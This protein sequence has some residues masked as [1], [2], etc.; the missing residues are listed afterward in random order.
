MWQQHSDSSGQLGLYFLHIFH[1][2]LMVSHIF[3]GPQRLEAQWFCVPGSCGIGHSTTEWYQAANK[4][5][6]N[7]FFSPS[8]WNQELDSVS[9]HT[10]YY[11]WKPACFPRKESVAYSGSGKDWKK[12]NWFSSFRWK[13]AMLLHVLHTARWDADRAES[14]K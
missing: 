12:R 4:N 8:T 2:Q 11:Q 7:K 9:E 3:H 13:H 10:L 6:R 1:T 14:M 5:S